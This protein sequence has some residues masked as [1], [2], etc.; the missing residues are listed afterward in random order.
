VRVGLGVEVEVDLGDGEP[1]GRV[2]AERKLFVGQGV[3]ERRGFGSA[4]SSD[5]NG[6]GHGGRERAHDLSRRREGRIAHHVRSGGRAQC[7]FVHRLVSRTVE[8][9]QRKFDE[10]VHGLDRCPIRKDAKGPHETCVALLVS[11]EES[12]HPCARR[13]HR[14]PERDGLFRDGRDRLEHSLVTLGEV[15][16]RR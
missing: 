7:P 10:Q 11:P 3:H 9:V 4:V 16:R 1:A 2:G 13:R 6:S 12:L 15:A 8:L 14:G 5:V